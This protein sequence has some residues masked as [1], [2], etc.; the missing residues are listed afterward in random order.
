MANIKEL[1][2]DQALMRELLLDHYQYPHNHELVQDGTY[3]SKHMASASCIDDITVQADIEDGTI[4]DLRFDGVACTISTASTS[5]MTELLK[6][7]TVEEA[8]RIIGEYMKM[9]NNEEYDSEALE[10]ANVFQ[11]VYKQANRIKCATIGWD[12]VKEI[13]EEK[14]N[15]G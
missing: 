1:F 9:I 6:G 2:N 3:L 4:R 7:K 12:A 10:E 14:E 13:I 5:I 11:N 15:N 8:K